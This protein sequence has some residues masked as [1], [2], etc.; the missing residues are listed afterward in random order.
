M[1]AL[2]AHEPLLELPRGV[3]AA[4]HEEPALRKRIE[5]GTLLFIRRGKRVNLQPSAAC[6]LNSRQLVHLR[7]VRFGLHERHAPSSF[8]GTRLQG[9]P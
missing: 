4:G 9:V 6:P 2:E 7:V 1:L 3:G 5:R 8:T